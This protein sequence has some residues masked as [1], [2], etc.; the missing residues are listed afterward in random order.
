MR[1]AQHAL[2]QIV[3][4]GLCAPDEGSRAS[5]HDVRGSHEW[6]Q[7]GSFNIVSVLSKIGNLRALGCLELASRTRHLYV[8]EKAFS[9]RPPPLLVSWRHKWSAHLGV[10]TVVV[11]QLDYDQNL[12]ASQPFSR[13]TADRKSNTASAGECIWVH[14]LDKQQRFC[15]LKPP[16]IDNSKASKISNRV[17]QCCLL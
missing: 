2:P 4:R 8:L 15:Q 5:S 16:N 10:S 3:Y 11:V 7:A 12:C 13:T 1:Q 14:A 6:Y 9:V 17:I